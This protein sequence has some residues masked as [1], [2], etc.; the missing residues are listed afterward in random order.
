PDGNVALVWDAIPGHSYRVQF[1]SALEEAE[2]TDLP[3][4]VWPDGITASRSG[5]GSTPQGFYRVRVLP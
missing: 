3:G 4:D 5:G 1:K 2:W